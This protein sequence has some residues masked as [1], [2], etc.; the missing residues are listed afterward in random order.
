M[1]GSHEKAL[2][3]TLFHSAHYDKQM[4]PVLHPSLPL[5]VSFNMQLSKLVDLNTKSQI[6]QTDVWIT[7]KWV[8]PFLTWNVSEYGGVHSIHVSP[9][10]V[11]VPDTVLYNRCVVLS[12]SVEKFKTDVVVES[13]GLCTWMSPATF[14]SS[15][16]L[17]VTFFPFDTQVCSMVFGSWTYDTRLLRLELM[18][19]LHSN[20]DHFTVNGDW[21]VENI[22]LR[23]RDTNYTCCAHPFS[24]I[25]FSFAL[26][27][28]PLY[29]V[30]Y[31][32]LPCVIIA[33]LT[34]VCFY[35]PV[36][37]GER[38][39]LCITILLAMSVY[40]FV[41][42]QSLPENSNTIPLLGIYYMATMCQVGAA[43]VATAVVLRCHY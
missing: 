40:L 27:R 26:E 37:C 16:V 20:A 38:I 19:Q 4:R 3:D 22:S 2:R 21:K 35:V 43:I 1:N 15:C 11:W 28:L 23:Q 14:K 12:G 18:A 25:V 24:D 36:E 13:D 29:H 8:N 41:V 10:D 30:I 7:Q 6:L 9:L 5:N 33:A 31:V 34:L 39:G 42:A 32:V 17:D